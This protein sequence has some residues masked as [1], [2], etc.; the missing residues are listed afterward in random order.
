MQ[1]FFLRAI[2]TFLQIS[3]KRR[4]ILLLSLSLS[5]CGL[6]IADSH[7]DEE[8]QGKSAVEDIPKPSAFV[9]EHR[10]EFNGKALRY[11]A[12]AG[13]TYIRD[14]QG[15]PRASIFSF[16][17]LALDDGKNRPVTF[18][19]N[20]GPGSASLWLHMGTF[21]PKRVAVPSDAKHAG[22]PPFPVVNASETILD[23]TDLVFVDPVGTGYSR[24]LGNHEGKEFWGL[25]EDAE[26]MSDFIRVWLSDNKRWNSPKF[27][28]G[29][30]F[31]TTRA[32]LVAELLEKNYNVALNG[33]VFISQALDYAGS[34]P[35]IAD[36]LISH[37]TYL[38]TMAATAYYHGKVDPGGKSL[39]EWVA[40]AREFATQRLLPA[41]F[42]GNTL[43][44]QTRE[45]VR[46]ELAAFTGLSAQYIERAGLRVRG[47][48]FAKE[49]MREE[50][51]TVGL[52]DSRYI[53][54]PVDDLTART[55]FDAASNATSG[56]YTAA[57][58]T[59]LQSDLG[60]NWDRSYLSPADPKLSEE[61]NWNPEGR[62]ESWEPHWVNTTPQLVSAMEVNPSLRVLVA[63]GYYDLVTPFF[64]AEYTL[65]RHGIDAKRI[66][67]RYYG[68]GHMMYLNEEARIKLLEDVR[69]FMSSQ[70]R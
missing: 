35:Y 66:D 22:V 2:T 48:R 23:I 33:L 31:G 50:G 26:S 20:G 67:Y 5:F 17:Y 8:S 25:T 60:V 58:M 70:L 7:R 43:D 10:G 62:E 34:S 41:L 65:N 61:W 53:G 38:P 4:T 15:E 36:N 40:S 46:D 63:S 59:Y 49:L 45:A 18:V 28:L 39:E 12:R 47:F 21:G 27:L 19:W 51:K 57:L 1:T 44:A 55:S 29:E 54:D 52:L 42:R 11:E 37:V 14:A 64:D 56:A 24:A 3:A 16:D 6:A 69:V 9:T 68:G 13:E 32:A 30:S